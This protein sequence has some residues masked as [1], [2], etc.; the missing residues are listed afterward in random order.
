[1]KISGTNTQLVTIDISQEE[2]LS[3]SMDNMTSENVY[4]LLRNTL[5]KG[6]KLP[7]DAY[8]S[9]DQW[10]QEVEFYG[11]HSYFSTQHI[12]QVTNEDRKLLKILDDLEEVLVKYP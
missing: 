9:G 10:V 7:Y 11:S 6:M 4:K 2:L 1:M 3:V 8:V 5:Y 12:R